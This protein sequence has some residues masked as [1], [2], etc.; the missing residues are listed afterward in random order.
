[1]GDDASS[2]GRKEVDGMCCEDL[3]CARC[4]GPVAEGRCASCRAARDSMHQPSITIT[5]QVLI[6]I[7]SVL[8][9]LTLLAVRH[10]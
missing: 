9:M 6:V 5:P 8:L 4:A 3:I 2:T 1:E 7:V 10:G